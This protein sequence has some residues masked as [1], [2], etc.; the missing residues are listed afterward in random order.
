MPRPSP[1]RALPVLLGLALFGCAEPDPAGLQIQN[2]QDPA[3][4]GFHQFGEVA[5]G[6]PLERSVLLANREGAPLRIRAVLPGCGCAAPALRFTDAAGE[7]QL[8]RMHPGVEPV[9]LPRGTTAELLLDI[10]TAGV[11]TI[12]RPYLI[13]VRIDTDSEVHPYLTLELALKVVRP[14][15]VLPLVL[16]MKDVPRSAGGEGS[17]EIVSA[18]DDGRRIAGIASSSPELEARLERI[19]GLQTELWRLVAR[20]P[21]PRSPGPYRGEIALDTTGPFGEGEGPPLRIP[22][23]AAVGEDVSVS[24]SQMLFGTVE[25]GAERAIEARLWARVPGQRVRI[26]AAELEG[27][28][29]DLLAF[30]FQPVLPDP[31]GRSDRWVLR[32]RTGGDLPAGTFRGTVVLSTDDPQLGEIRVPYGGVVRP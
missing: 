12:N 19:E 29:G 31:V 17:V 25:V 27:D 16:D 6:E 14:F 26:L 28:H 18:D 13:T 22:V 7:E 20:L 23:R 3:R 32:M 11:P 2:P 5:Y 15:T 4:P 21:G 30:D 8:R 9:L 10:D 1:L 24:P